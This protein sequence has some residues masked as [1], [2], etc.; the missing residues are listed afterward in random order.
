MIN[1]GTRPRVADTIR[2]SGAL[3]LLSR[4]R[5]DAL[6]VITLTSSCSPFLIAIRRSQA[7][8]TIKEIG[9]GRRC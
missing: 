3:D 8:D 4:F 2:V 1:G 6:L 5:D 9:L 7:F